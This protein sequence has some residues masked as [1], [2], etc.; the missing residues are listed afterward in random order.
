MYNIMFQVTR[1]QSTREHSHDGDA[2]EIDAIKLRK[3]L[4]N[5]ADANSGNSGQILA[6]KLVSYPW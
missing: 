1:V 4:M 3:E 2:F 6:D 5:A